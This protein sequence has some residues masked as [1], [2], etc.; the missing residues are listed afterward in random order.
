L[1]PRPAEHF[2]ILLNITLFYALRLF[3]KCW[4]NS[5]NTTSSK[6]G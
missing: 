6:K 3:V 5:A 4:L 2:V 1:N